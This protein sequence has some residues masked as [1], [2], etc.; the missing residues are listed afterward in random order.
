MVLTDYCSDMKWL[1][2][3]YQ[4]KLAAKDH[5]E[6]RLQSMLHNMVNNRNQVACFKQNINKLEDVNTKVK[7]AEEDILALRGKIDTIDKK[8]E[9]LRTEQNTIDGKTKD[10]LNKLTA[11]ESKV[12]LQ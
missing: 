4:L 6:E 12:I 1:E 2:E 10:I 8:I 9:A 3:E 11:G 7:Y 5:Q